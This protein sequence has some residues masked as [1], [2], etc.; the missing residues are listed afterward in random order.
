MNQI[1]KLLLKNRGWSADMKIEL[2]RLFHENRI[3]GLLIRH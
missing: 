3:I 1:I 2:Y